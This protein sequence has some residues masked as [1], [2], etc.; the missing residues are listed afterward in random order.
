MSPGFPIR[1]GFTAALA[2]WFLVH[3][4]GHLTPAEGYALVTTL[5]LGHGILSDLLGVPLDFTHLPA[6]IA[7]GLSNVPMSGTLETAAVPTKGPKAPETP[8]PAR[9]TPAKPA[10]SST[11]STGTQGAQKKGESKKGK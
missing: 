9:S 8:R 5:F 3:V 2:Y 1:S 7:H 10:A 4:F 11:T 6:R